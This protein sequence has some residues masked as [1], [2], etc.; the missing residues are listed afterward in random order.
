M[1]SQ[2]LPHRVDIQYVA[3]Q[4]QNPE[5]GAITPVWRD[6]FTDEPAEIEYVTGREY[7]ASA[8]VQHE[9]IARVTV[10]QRPEG[11]NVLQPKQRIV[12]GV[13][14]C[15]HRGREVFNPA[16]MLPDDEMGWFFV[17]IPCSRNTDDA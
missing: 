8:A 12:H 1:E 13:K 9:I 5:T 16:A 17:T 6:K 4:R 14:C 3:S 10:R 11:V 7:V 2:A 15:K